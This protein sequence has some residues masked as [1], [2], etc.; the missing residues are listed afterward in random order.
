MPWYR[1]ITCWLWGREELLEAARDGDVA[2]V[3]RLAALG[4]DVNVANAGRARPL[5]IAA[6]Y[7]HVEA[8]RALAELG[9]DVDAA[10]VDGQTPL[11]LTAR[12]GH[13]EAM[14]ALVELGAQQMSLDGGRCTRPRH[15]TDT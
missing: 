15:S 1:H 13:V 8:I 3:Q 2:K 4:V 11:H 9:A 6:L 14:R 10:G 12:F 7:G 5:Q